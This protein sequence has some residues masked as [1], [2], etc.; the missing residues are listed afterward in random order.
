MSLYQE[1]TI[2]LKVS[3]DRIVCERINQIRSKEAEGLKTY[4]DINTN[5]SGARRKFKGD[6]R[7][8]FADENLK[9]S[10]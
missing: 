10:N 6:V 9:F 5:R 3:S 2:K 4:I 1:D 8:D 7:L